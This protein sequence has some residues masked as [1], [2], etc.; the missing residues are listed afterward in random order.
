MIERAAWLKKQTRYV[1]RLYVAGFTPRSARAI[2]SVKDTCEEYLKGSYDLEIIDIYQHP[3]LAKGEQ[4]I[5]APTL[6]RKL[7][8]PLRRLIGDMADQ[9]K[10]LVGLDLRARKEVNSGQWGKNR[11]RGLGAR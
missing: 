4:I 1:L 5:A 9:E 2:Q 11:G 8:L 7:P 6:I 10:V 3:T